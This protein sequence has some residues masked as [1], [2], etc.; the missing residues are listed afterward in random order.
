MIKLRR[1][2]DQPARKLLLWLVEPHGELPPETRLAL[3]HSL[4]TNSASF[5]IGLFNSL[6]ISIALAVHVA[7][8]PFALWA[9]FVALLGMARLPLLA[10]GRRA[11]LAGTRGPIEIHTALALAW[12]ATIGFGSFI[13]IASGDWIAITLGCL[14]VAGLVG[15]TCFRNFAAPRI[16][17]A[18]IL[19]S[20]LPCAT[21]A[22]LSGDLLLMIVALQ[23]PLFAASMAIAAFRLNKMMVRT[24]LAERETEQR[25]SQDALTGLLNRAG[26]ARTVAEWTGRNES[27]ALHYLNLDGFKG[28]NDR[29]GHQAGDELLKAVAERLR[30][31]CRPEDA[32]ARIGGDEFVV[33]AAGGDLVAARTVGARLVAAIGQRGFCIDDEAAFIG[34]SVGIA[35]F[36]DHGMDLGALLGEA[37]AALYQA[38]FW[39]RSRYVVARQQ[40]RAQSSGAMAV[41]IP[42][43][44]LIDRSAA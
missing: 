22:L 3:L 11:V 29:L 15:G 13:S 18:M 41:P 40:P 9:A 7:T 31:I 23:L 6:L 14:S 37:D 30:G 38:K 2:D 8:P 12:A 20:L 10:A 28:I 19:L 26:L 32:V 25:A 35:L 44:L 1:K 39:G 42:R 5:F 27:F 36:P 21:A 24:M 4:Y 43:K 17:V 34:V 16:V 33:L